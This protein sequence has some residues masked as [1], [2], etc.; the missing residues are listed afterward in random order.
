MTLEEN[1]Y[2]DRVFGEGALRVELSEQSG[3]YTG[4]YDWKNK[5]VPLEPTQDA[6]GGLELLVTKD[7]TM[8]HFQDV[9]MLPGYRTVELMALLSG[10][11]IFRMTDIEFLRI[12]EPNDTLRAGKTDGHVCITREGKDVARAEVESYA[13]GLEPHA[14]GML[15]E[16]AAQTIGAN[17][18]QM[19]DTTSLRY[20]LLH[21]CRQIYAAPIEEDGL[22]TVRV[23]SLVQEG[24]A[25]RPKYRASAELYNP[26]EEVVA[27]VGVLSLLFTSKDQQMALIEMSRNWS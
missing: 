18:S 1:D 5:V 7:H 15:L 2:L 8:G 6:D 19:L 12:V 27:F 21:S 9:K 4:S 20:P 25:R 10:S 16:L 23:T 11:P 24:L 14:F 3:R 26:H 22:L 17:V 13:D